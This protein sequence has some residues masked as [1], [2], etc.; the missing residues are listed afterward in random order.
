ML[1][2]ITLAHPELYRVDRETNMASFRR[3]RLLSPLKPC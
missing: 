1:T 2:L 3:F